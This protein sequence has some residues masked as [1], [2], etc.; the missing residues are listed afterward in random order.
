MELWDTQKLRDALHVL[1]DDPAVQEAARISHLDHIISEAS[2]P[3]A[4]GAGDTRRRAERRRRPFWAKL[5]T[6]IDEII[7]TMRDRAVA[8]AAAAVARRLDEGGTGEGAMDRSADADDWAELVGGWCSAMEFFAES[9]RALVLAESGPRDERPI[10]TVARR[11]RRAVAVMERVGDAYDDLQAISSQGG[12]VPMEQLSEIFL[13]VTAGAHAEN[14]WVTYYWR[15][16]FEI[17]AAGCE[18]VGSGVE[19]A[20]VQSWL[21][22]AMLRDREASSPHETGLLQACEEALAAAKKQNVVSTRCMSFMAVH[23]VV[24]SRRS[25]AEEALLARRRA[26]VPQAAVMRRKFRA[27]SYG[28]MNDPSGKRG[29]AKLFGRVD[30]DHSGLI[31][32]H[33]LV[34]AAKR[35]GR[36]SISNEDMAVIFDEIDEDKDGVISVDEFSDWCQQETGKQSL[37][38]VPEERASESGLSPVLE[39]AESA[40]ERSPASES[41]E[42]LVRAE[43]GIAPSDQSPRSTQQSPGQSPRS[44]A[45]QSPAGA[46]LDLVRGQVAVSKGSERSRRRRQQHRGK[47]GSGKAKKKEAASPYG[48]IS[49]AMARVDELGKQGGVGIG[50]GANLLRA[51]LIE[52]RMEG[53]KKASET[54]A[55]KAR[56]MRQ[57]Q[58][59]AAGAH[60]S[61]A[62]DEAWEAP[63]EVIASASHYR[64]P[65]QSGMQ[66]PWRSSTAAD[67]SAEALNS[68]E[69]SPVAAV[70]VPQA[71]QQG[72]S[73]SSH[74]GI[75][76]SVARECVEELTAGLLHSMFGSSEPSKQRQNHTEHAPDQI[77]PRQRQRKQQQQQ[78]RAPI[79]D[80]YTGSNVS[81][82]PNTR[83]RQQRRQ[84]QEGRAIHRPSAGLFA[85][86]R[87]ADARERVELTAA[88]T[89]IQAVHRGRSARAQVVALREVGSQ[90]NET[91]KSTRSHVEENPFM[92]SQT[93]SMS[94]TATQEQFDTVA[95]QSDQADQVKAATTM[96]AVQRGRVT[97]RSMREGKAAT[98][99]QAVQR[100]RVTRRRMREGKAATTMQA[101]QRGRV[102]RRGRQSR[103]LARDERRAATKIQARI[104][105]RTARR[106]TR[107]TNNQRASAATQK[108]HTDAATKI[109]ARVRGRAA[110]RATAARRAEIA[111]AVAEAK[112]AAEAPVPAEDAAASNPAEDYPAQW[113]VFT[114]LDED[115]SGLLGEDEVWDWVAEKDEQVANE[116]MSSLDVNNDGEIDFSEFLT[117]WRLL[118]TDSSSVPAAEEEQDEAQELGVEQDELADDEVVE[119]ADDAAASP[120][121]SSSLPADQGESTAPKG[122]T[123]G[124]PTMARLV[125][126]PISTNHLPKKDRKTTAA[127]GRKVVAAA[128]PDGMPY[129]GTGTTRQQIARQ[130]QAAF[131][132]IASGGERLS[133]MAQILANQIIEGKRKAAKAAKASKAVRSAAAGSGKGSRGHPA[134]VRGKGRSGTRPAVAA[135]AAVGGDENASK[136]VQPQQQQHTQQG[137]AAGRT[138]ARSRKAGGAG[139]GPARPRNPPK[140]ENE[141]S[142]DDNG[143]SSRDPIAEVVREI[144]GGAV[145]GA[146]RTVL[147]DL[148]EHS[149]IKAVLS[150]PD[151]GGGRA[152]RHPGRGGNDERPMMRGMVQPVSGSGA[153]A[154]RARRA[155][156]S[157]VPLPALVSAETQ[158]AR[159]Y[160][161][162]AASAAGR[163]RRGAGGRRAPRQR[164]SAA[165]VALPPLAAGVPA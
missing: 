37:A 17:L 124:E 159:A 120:S 28:E 45:S 83:R 163:S 29:L 5:R 92:I 152:R 106:S 103:V 94:G 134:R 11:C 10:P 157:G 56:A 18:M 3:A 30:G 160:G 135:A 148:R 140:N 7:T 64:P 27:A 46:P 93:L 38:L 61:R 14:G 164:Q 109:Q 133:P 63:T 87:A 68:A 76:D 54:K 35:I 1:A 112:A 22:R 89:R 91:L 156:G 8:L 130:D 81:V 66:P 51:E 59:V 79:V 121:P 55:T 77:S 25:A 119:R 34:T 13:P 145:S 129:A 24:E 4:G 72:D 100:G 49:A 15:T 23:T 74:E 153:K 33:E 70:A 88:A 162:S 155:S 161:S 154:V 96:Q 41:H 48:D 95:A 150:A 102:A 158:R 75:E 99:M 53:K 31:D 147:Q 60:E 6:E 65:R 122:D 107:G 82:A 16:Y 85:D 127:H 137:A 84:Q 32:Y 110:R 26:I 165:A 111:A 80:P 44:V 128:A 143:G 97:R 142:G 57:Q 136:S 90:L 36:Y 114:E 47:Q 9:A 71:M 115:D 98:T 20:D 117:I 73:A 12:G 43:A 149:A 132:R 40:G 113:A 141:D 50:F 19:K 58:R 131:K 126:K 101:V 116:I 139:P 42:G 104:R 125:E 105:G 52:K 86:E 118:H 108:D 123:E 151:L 78:Q 146:V 39:A 67:N 62:I 21:E 2:E 69:A 144:V 138:R